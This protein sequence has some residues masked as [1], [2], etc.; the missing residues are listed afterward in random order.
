MNKFADNPL[1]GVRH[2]RMAGDG[3]I[4]HVARAGSGRPVILLH[5][6]PESWRSWRAQIPA[7]ANAGFSVLAPDLRGYNQSDIP[8][9][10]DAYELPHLVADVEALVRAT[11]ESRVCLVGHDWGGVVAWAFARDHPGLLE[12]LAIV[13]APHPHLY[14]QQAKWPPQLLRSWYVAFFL[15]PGLSELVLSARRFHALRRMFRRSPARR[16]TFTE[17]DIDQYIEGISQPGALTA[18]LNY[19]RANVRLGAT[20]HWPS[21]SIDVDT[22]VLWGEQDPALDLRLLDGLDRLVPRL[23]IHRFP[24]ASHWV[25]NEAPEE[26]NRVLTQFLLTD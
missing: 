24:H 18:A 3:V 9:A 16:G 7:L 13:N 2:E 22:L 1:A 20:R 8:P 15:V 10:R 6:F 17:E 4:L 14:I 25:Q 19:Y 26:F 12:K 5:G 23:R 11:G 21:A